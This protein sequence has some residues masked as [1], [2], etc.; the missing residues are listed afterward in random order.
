MGRRSTKDNKNIYQISREEAGLTREKA[1]EMMDFV[2]DDRIEKIESEKSEPRPEEI[3]AMAEAY[4]KPIL[5]NY[6]CSQSC[7]IGREYVPALKHKEL[8]Q[9]VLELLSYLTSL[10]KERD[11]FIEISHDGEISEDEYADFAQIQQKLEKLSVTADALQLWVRKK[12]ADGL[13]DRQKFENG[14]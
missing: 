9:I 13:I 14:L 6:Y 7:P 10:E 4:K 8:T 5:C 11:R 2:S 3:L 12:I 1:A